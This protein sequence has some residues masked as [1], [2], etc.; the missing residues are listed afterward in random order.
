MSTQN[1]IGNKESFAISYEFFDET[2]ETELSMFID[3]QNILEFERNGQNLTTRW[4]LDDLVEWLRRF[5]DNMAEDPFPFEV[6]GEYGA[7]KDSAAREFDTDDDEEFDAYYDKLELWDL[8]HRWHTESEGAIL[9]DLYFQLVGEYVEISW[10]NEDSEDGVKFK[11][12]L[13]GT[14]IPKDKFYSIVDSFIK[15]YAVHWF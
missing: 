8:R 1:I 12:E 14:K 5:I 7:Y 2:R 9:A 11:S 3:G 6:E 4:N 13:G 10:N 15:E